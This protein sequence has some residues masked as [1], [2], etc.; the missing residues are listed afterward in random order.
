MCKEAVHAPLQKISKR[1][2]PES[3]KKTLVSECS[4]THKKTDNHH[5]E[6]DDHPVK[7]HPKKETGVHYQH[8]HPESDYQHHLHDDVI[9]LAH[10]HHDHQHLPHQQHQSSVRA[11]SCHAGDGHNHGEA[12]PIAGAISSLPMM[13]PTFSGG[14][15]HHHEGEHE[16]CPNCDEHLVD[17]DC[18][19]CGYKHQH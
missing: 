9:S 17:N 6:H 5:Q 18:P 19:K 7:A 15:H 16:H 1:L 4:H 10:R 11:H 13:K 8:P 2:N 3:T 12:M 14:G